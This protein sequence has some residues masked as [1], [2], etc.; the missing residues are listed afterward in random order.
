MEL[1]DDSDLYT[2]KGGR[3]SSSMSLSTLP[4][5]IL[6]NVF[7]YLE[8]KDLYAIQL[9]SKRFYVL[10][11]DEELWKNLF[12]TKF[13]TKWFPTYSGSSKYSI[14]FIN[15]EVGL[16]EWKHNKS[17]RTKYV[18]ATGSRV[19]SP[20]ENMLFDYP[21]CLCYSDGVITM[22]QLQQFRNNRGNRARLTYIPC[23]TPHGCSTMNF[24]INSAIF[25]R[26]DGRLYGKILNNKSYLQPIVEFDS[27]HSAP[28]TAIA[29]KKETNDNI[30]VSGSENGDLI[31]WEDTKKIKDMKISNLPIL[32]LGINKDY[33]IALDSQSIYV[34]YQMNVVRALPLPQQINSTEGSEENVPNASRSQ[35]IQVQFCKF[36]FGSSSIV[37]ADTK[38]MYVITLDPHSDTFGYIRKMNFGNDQIEEVVIDEPT[39]LKP[40]NLEVAGESGCFIAVK[41]FLSAVKIINIRAPGS[42]LIV[43]TELTVNDDEKIFTCQITNLVIVCAMN[44]FIN[45]YDNL[46]GEL[47]KTIQKTEKIPSFLRISQGRLLLSNGENV[48]QYIKFIPDDNADTH[49]SNR[50]GSAN[51]NSN[52]WKDTLNTALSVYEEEEELNE[53]QRIEAT[54]LL[55]TYGGDFEEELDSES[56]EI[57]L[58]IALMESERIQQEQ[59]DAE[60]QDDELQRALRESQLINQDNGILQDPNS[61]DADGNAILENDDELLRALRA[62]QVEEVNEY[63]NNTDSQREGSNQADDD[64]DIQ[65]AI[66]LSL[67]ELDS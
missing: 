26:F 37:L 56:E 10:I 43:Q 22:L 40:Q 51:K 64:D 2:S 5:E 29:I 9:L 1:L 61:I 23:T 38:D 50:S 44:G 63:E 41:T 19:A 16:K 33:T 24:G 11:N 58:R 48:I 4:S 62:S 21:R 45:I 53:R 60:N 13:N 6:I 14:E 25:G 42:K 35:Y 66:A 46:N 17:I 30:C 52:K 67:S 59:L 55:N 15:R 36:D 54:R 47:I 3:V 28:V 39:A 57:T 8:E 65:L 34:I 32:N 7:S 12:V 18:I 49:R 31:W 20:L 27:L